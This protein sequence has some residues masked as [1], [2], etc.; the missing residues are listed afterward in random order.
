MKLKHFLFIPFLFLCWPLWAADS[1]SVPPTQLARMSTMI[2]GSTTPAGSSTTT[3]VA[4][5]CQAV[6]KG[7]VTTGTNVQSLGYSTALAYIANRIVGLGAFKVCKVE[8]GLQ[9]DGTPGDGEEIY[10]YL[11]GDN[12]GT[13]KPDCTATPAKVAST[14][15][16]TLQADTL[17]A[18]EAYYAF[19]FNNI[20]VP[21]PFWIVAYYNPLNGT[22]NTNHVNWFNNNTSSTGKTC[23]SADASTWANESTYILHYKV[24]A[25][26]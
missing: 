18:G 23:S 12:S 5:S 1:S 21:D 9:K 13:V 14:T 6:A 22:P 17:G 7:S 16:P 8:I 3:T 26:E 4:A 2:V 20:D 24:Y 15:S 10:L 19:T 25:Y 11:C